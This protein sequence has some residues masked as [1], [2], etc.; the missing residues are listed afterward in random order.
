M[1]IAVAGEDG[2]LREHDDVE[3]SVYARTLAMDVEH[4]GAVLAE[5]GIDLGD[6]VIDA[7]VLAGVQTVKVRSVLTCESLV[8][9]C[10]YCYGRSLAS[11]KLVDIGEAASSRPSRSV[12][13]APS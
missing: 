3:T 13:P 8:G 12:S 5:A 4:G 10:A 6:V 9:T 2:V 1:P 7:L 11:G